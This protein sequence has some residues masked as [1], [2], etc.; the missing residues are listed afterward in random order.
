MQNLFKWDDKNRQ[1]DIIFDDYNQNEYALVK[2]IRYSHATIYLSYKPY[3]KF[4]TTSIC[5]DVAQ[6]NTNKPLFRDDLIKWTSK[7]QI[8][9]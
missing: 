7:K 1:S 5:Q 9:V 4:R 6:S 3:Y 8:T 2:I